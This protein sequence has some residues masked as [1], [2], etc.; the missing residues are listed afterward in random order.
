[1]ASRILGLAR[2]GIR[3]LLR[4]LPKLRQ[5][6]FVIAFRIQTCCAICSPKALSAFVLL[7]RPCQRRKQAFRLSSL[8]TTTLIV[9]LSALVVLGVVFAEP[10]F[11][12]SRQ[13]QSEPAKFELTVRLTRIAMP[14]IVLMAQQRSDG[15]SERAIASAYRPRVVIL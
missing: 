9:V 7:F 2:N 8:V 10:S 13:V 14:F 3:L 1:M 11:G 12:S 4:R 5:R 15:S 6:A